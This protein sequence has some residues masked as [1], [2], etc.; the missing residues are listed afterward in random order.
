MQTE[1]AFLAALPRRADGV[2]QRWSQATPEAAALCEGGRALSFARLEQITEGFARRLRQLGVGGG[3]RVLIVGENSVAM[4][5]ML[6]A[7]SRLDAWAVPVNARLSARE[8]DTIGEHCGA[9]RALYAVGSSVE[10][11]A[12]AR[13]HGA[14]WETI[15][16]A[17]PIAI[18]PLNT[19]CAP[20]A[21][22]P[23]P[24][25]QVAALLYTSGTTGHP[26]GVMLSHRNLAFIAAISAQL[27]E[28]TPADRI[29]GVLPISHV[30][31]FASVLFG[32]LSAGACLVLE[33]RFTAEKL[34]RALAT[35]GI[36]VMLGVPAMFAR[37]LELARSGPVSLSAPQLR[38]LYAGGAP[39][40]QSLKDAVEQGFGKTIH[41][42]YGMTESSPTIAQ[43]RPAAPRTDCS[44]GLP[45][46]Y[47]GVRL[48][49]GEGHEVAQGETGEIWV[50][51]PNVMKGYYRDPE[52][53]AQTLVDG[54]WLKT[55]DLA[56]CDA[57]G[58]LF[59]VGRSKELIIR[60][61]FNVYPVEVEALLN[62]HPEVTQSAVVGR[63]CEG[64]EEV[65]AFVEVQAGSQITPD[66]ISAWAAERLTAYKR[67]SQIIIEAQL[68][69]AAT[70]K[71]LKHRLKEMARE[72]L[73]AGRNGSSD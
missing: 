41:N 46:P 35:D 54:E 3:D 72:R 43:T 6:L 60:S 15:A 47:V 52:L 13:R 48:V 28:L 8:L 25:L 21:V 53:T 2:V 32:T 38:F 5:V 55:G 67:P 50:R 40:D 18:G 11:L 58:A 14:R 61:G 7:A 30:F 1:A 56:R 16:H 22:S 29:Y 49:D 73:V 4:A 23:E 10:A 27:R 68:P 37:L 26:K 63:A 70:G 42:G 17:G 24:E 71:L 36:T 62:S 31:G 59:L 44:V 51:G 19:T 57:D 45:I 39:L 66:E 65:V 64:N 33:A 9:R 20:Q 34:A 12:H 69:A